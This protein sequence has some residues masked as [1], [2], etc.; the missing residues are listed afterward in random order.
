MATRKEPLKRATKSAPTKPKA[1]ASGSAKTSSPFPADFPEVRARLERAVPEAVC[2]LDHR[3]PFELLIA[4]ILSA[5]STDK[6]VNSVTPELFRRWPSSQALA[7]APQEEVETVIKRT[8]F[9]R[10]KAKSIRGTAQALVDR[11]AGEV[12]RTLEQLIELPGVA[13][14]TA[15][16]VLGTGYRIASGFVVDT[17]VSRVAQ[18]L[19]LSS[20]Q[21][22]IKIEADLCRGFPEEAWVDMS[23]R[24]LLHGR[25]TCLA[26]KPICRDC[27]LNELCPARESAPRDTWEE[28]ADDEAAR[29]ATARGAV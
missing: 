20:A 29:L 28:R 26:K 12:P 17:H 19:R 22:P 1:R 10:N 15:N 11:H 18:R 24:V 27:A 5:Q 16:V 2:E 25:Y 7:G 4:T 23:H 8:G 14:K 21:E 6:M 3:S 13:R 9:F